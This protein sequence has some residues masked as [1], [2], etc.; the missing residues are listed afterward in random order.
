MS[1]YIFV[2]IFALFGGIALLGLWK[3]SEES[4]HRSLQG[5]LVQDL[6]VPLKEGQKVLA[7]E[8]APLFD[9]RSQGGQ[10][11]EELSE[12]DL[13]GGFFAFDLT[14]LPFMDTVSYTTRVPW[15]SGRPAWVADYAAHYGTSRH[16]IARSLN[17]KVDYWNQKVNL[18]DR[19]NV[20][21]KDYPIEFHLVADLAHC[22]MWFYVVD[23]STGNRT[24]LKT[25]PIGV[26]RLDA[27]KASGSLTPVGTYRLGDK[28]AI[29]KPGTMGFFQEQK[30]EMV[31]VFGTRWIP[32]SSGS[33]QGSE[34]AK[35]FGLHGLPWR[36]DAKTKEMQ[37]DGSCLKTHSS[38][39]CIRM[40]GKDIEEL[41]A[42][43]ITKDTYIHVVK[44]FHE[45]QL[46]GHEAS[47][48]EW[49]QKASQSGDTKVKS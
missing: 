32:F 49:S 39:G 46:P 27:K 31:Q 5:A 11:N 42:I 41:F 25:Y 22:Q 2:L 10:E 36:L 8:V 48:A 18:G 1:K 47:L 43:V 16:L 26:G 3:G 38:D 34:S 9:H 33:N 12:V 19:F 23:V 6:S 28:V 21:K 20:F 7:P 30:T 45:V 37:E 44:D 17:Q 29:Y 15:L 24:L 13:V 4:R 40:A 35:G 14:R